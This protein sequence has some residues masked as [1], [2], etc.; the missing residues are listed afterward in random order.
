LTPALHTVSFLT[1]LWN[2]FLAISSK[3][4]E[5][6]LFHAGERSSS[7]CNSQATILLGH[8]FLAKLEFPI[9]GADFLKYFNLIVDLSASQL[10]ETGTLPPAACSASTQKWGSLFSAME[11][12]LL[13]FRGVFNKF[14]DVA[15]AS[16]SV[17]PAKH[18]T[19]H[20]IH[21]TGP[22]AKA[23]FCRLN[24]AKLAAAKAEFSKLEK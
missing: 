12:M 8:F 3:V 16:G 10:L 21:T 22:P 4:P 17:P 18:K 13:P 9:H 23:C 6:K 5:G 7:Q 14:Q 2:Q 1:N 15:N 19:V 11:S 20:H 24:A